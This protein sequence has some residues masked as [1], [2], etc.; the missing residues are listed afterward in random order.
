MFTLAQLGRITAI[1]ALVVEKNSRLK[2]AASD[3]TAE[4]VSPPRYATRFSLTP[5]H[6]T[7]LPL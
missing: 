4:E 5:N 7:C 3:V 1:I 6:V 2:Y